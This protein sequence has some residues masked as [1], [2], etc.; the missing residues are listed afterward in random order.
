MYHTDVKK[1]CMDNQAN[2]HLIYY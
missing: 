2:V 1:I